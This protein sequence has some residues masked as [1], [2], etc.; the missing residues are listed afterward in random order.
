MHQQADLWIDSTNVLWADVLYLL[1]SADGVEVGLEEKGIVKD[2][3][4]SV[5]SLCISAHDA[6]ALIGMVLVL[7]SAQRGSGRR[8]HL[9]TWGLIPYSILP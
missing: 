2:P 3:E 8:V 6:P 1:R 9:Q 7:F 5:Y 4:G